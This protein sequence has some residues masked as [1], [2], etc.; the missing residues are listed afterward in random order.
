MSSDMAAFFDRIAP[1]WDNTPDKYQTREELTSMMELPP[2]SV[3][4]DIGC[5]RGVMFEHLLKTDP[6]K[7]IAVDVSGEMIR[8]AKEQ[9]HDERIEYVNGDL[10]DVSL[11]MLDAAIFFNAYPHFLDK[12][13]LA[14]KLAKGIKKGGAMIIAHSLSRAE[15]NGVHSGE[16]VS[17]LSVALESA[18]DEARKFEQ[19][20]S[21]EALVD[22][23]KVFLVKMLRR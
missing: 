14:A 23:D 5:G 19:F 21:T 8:L 10:L 2:K 15:V 3:I 9:W 17:K 6:E 12:E 16:K 4:A 11:P 13:G 18:E 20:F 7:I 1:E 22:N